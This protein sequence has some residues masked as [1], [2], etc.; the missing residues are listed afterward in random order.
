M[1]HVEALVA[2]AAD[3]HRDQQ[4]DACSGAGVAYFAV[5]LIMTENRRICPL[6]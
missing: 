5:T 3:D 4:S 6:F 1:R 2:A